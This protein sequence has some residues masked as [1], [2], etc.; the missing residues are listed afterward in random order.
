MGSRPGAGSL[1]AVANIPGGPGPSVWNVLVK[2]EATAIAIGVVIG[3][4]VG[5][6]FDSIGTGI[7]LGLALVIA[8]APVIKERT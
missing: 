3:A 4:A 6:V 2:T 7:V 5:A 1:R 8:F